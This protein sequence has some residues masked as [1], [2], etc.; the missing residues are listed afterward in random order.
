MSY[1]SAVII[2]SQFH[3]ACVGNII[4]KLHCSQRVSSGHLSKK[5]MFT[6]AVIYSLCITRLK[7]PAGPPHVTFI[8]PRTWRPVQQRRD[9]AKCKHSEDELSD[10]VQLRKYGVYR[11]CFLCVT[12]ITRTTQWV[13]HLRVIMCLGCCH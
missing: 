10:R 1:K 11:G 7:S 8:E 5:E 2:H 4:F 13:V 6:S 9:A 12:P 3:D